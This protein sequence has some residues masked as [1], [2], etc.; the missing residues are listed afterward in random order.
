MKLAEISI[1]RPS[2]VIV[3]F[4]ILTLGGLLSYSMMGYELIPKFETNMVTISTVYP[5]ASPSEVETSVTRKIEDAV[6]SLENVKKVESSS[7]ESLSVIMV[8]LNT[9]AD[10]NYALNDAQRKVNA[11]L[12]DLPEDADP[13]SLQK[14]SLDDL[15]IMTLSITSD[16]LNNKELYDLLDKKIEPIFSR[17]NGV[18]QVDLVGGQEREIQVSLDEKKMQGYGLAIADVQ[19]AILSSNLD[20]PTG[21]LKTRTS[22]S[23]IRLSG[24]YRDVAEMNNLVVS[25]K[26]GAQV[27]LSDIATVLDTQKDVEKI[28]RYNQNSTILMQIK[29]QSDANAVSVSELVQKTIAQVQDNYKTQGVK[30][31]IVD[32]TTNFTLE[33]A[34]H[35]IFDLFLAIILVAVVM[36]LFLH[37][38][39]NAFIVMVSIPVSLIATVIGMYLM[40]YTLNLMSLLGLSLV[41]GI[42]VDDAIVVLENVYRHMEMGKSRIR[43]AYDGASEIGFTVTAITLVIVVVFLP[44]AMSSGLVSDILAQF[45]VTVVIATMLSLLASFTIIPWLS[46]RFGKLVHLTG[47]NPFEKF[48]LWFEKQLEKF[49]HWISGILEWCLKSTL[50]RIMTVIVTFI[51]LISS[52]MLVAFGFIGGEFFPKIDRGQFLVQMELSKDAS[53]EKTNQVT[54]AVEKYLRDDK[55]VVDMITT[56]GQQSSGFGGAQAT[57]YQSE[58]QVILVDKSERNESTDIKSAKIKR[59]L[60]EKFTG[61]EFKTAPIGLMGADNAPIEMVVTAQDNETANKEANRILELLKKVPGSVDAEL[62]TD[63]GSPEVQVNIDRDK[64]ASLGLN[65]SSVGQT[66]Q[67]AFSG[68]TDGKFRAGEY[69]YDIN[70]RFGDANRQSIDD[71]RNLMFT[72]PQ[73]QQVRLSQFADV[74]MGSGPSLLERRDKAP[75]V[76]VKS[77]VVGR[78]VGDVAN[79]W[80]DQ[81]MNNEKTKPAGVTYIWSGDMENQTEGFGTLGIALLAAIVLVYL[82]MV[83]LYDSFVYPFVVLF[84]IPLALIGVMVILA[85]TGNSLNIFTMLGMIMLIGLVAKNAIMIV[86]FANMRKAA[87]ANTHDA[88]IQAN[89]ARLRPILMTTIAMIFGMIPIAIAKGAGAEMNNGLAWVIIGGLTSSLFLTL[90]I[91]PVVYSLFDSLLRKMGKHETVDYDAEMKADYEHRELSEDGYTPKHVD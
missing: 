2:L 25:N 17:V 42:L 77:K 34:D 11:I 89:H 31:N 33:A 26:N 44:I 22:R 69:E 24:K 91:V 5:G 38:I 64:M 4:T 58:I 63:S 71:V 72:N 52:F 1:K 21:A 84:S 14:F 46:S 81:F 74:K 66:M 88:L 15:P 37:N 78:P 56:V 7:Y 67:T 16:K 70:I 51:I 65:L 43:A 61:V 3:L 55:D 30:V 41:V 57:L 39:R 23:T 40:G 45:C 9:G 10:V 59:A 35:V 27:R 87:G 13:P 68:N 85:I 79:E 90:I 19:Q 62:S 54:L 6:G 86:D 36:L 49:T 60:E 47:K 73:G 12:A 8:Q 18:A 50:R 83:S 76:K 20:F 75:S 53:V 48:I 28:A 80:A 29:K 32:D 82:V